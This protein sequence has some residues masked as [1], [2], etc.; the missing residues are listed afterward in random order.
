MDKL[1][2]IVWRGE[3]SGLLGPNGAG[4]TAAIL[5]FLGL[6]EPTAG[7]VQVLG[8]PTRQPLSVKARVSTQV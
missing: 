5:M 1:N 2:L 3:V 7:S 8:F 4:K 6:T